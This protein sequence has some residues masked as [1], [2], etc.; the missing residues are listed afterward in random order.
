MRVDLT[1]ETRLLTSG[2]AADIDAWV[3]RTLDENGG[4]RLEYQF[5]LD[6]GQPEENCLQIT[7]TLREFS[8]DC[9]RVPVF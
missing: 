2:T 9:R 4:G 3:R 1:P 8:V 6:A 7:R 5:H